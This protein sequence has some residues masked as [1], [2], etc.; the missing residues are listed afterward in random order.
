MELEVRYVDGR[1]EIEPAPLKVDLVRRGR[2]VV[3][4][5]EAATEALTAEEVERTRSALRD[6]RSC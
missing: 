1:V 2:F 4:V 6:S 5:P 3:A